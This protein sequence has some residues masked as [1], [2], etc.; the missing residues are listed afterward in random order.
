MGRKCLFLALPGN[1]RKTKKKAI[2]SG[3][4]AISGIS[5]LI[6]IRECT[7]NKSRLSKV[8]KIMKESALQVLKNTQD[9]S[10]VS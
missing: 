5:Y 10:I 6:S 9:S 3:E 4:P 1:Q 8:E 7:E 2:A